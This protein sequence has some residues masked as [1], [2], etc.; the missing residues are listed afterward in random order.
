M[1]SF[2]VGSEGEI[3][4]L[5][6]DLGNFDRHWRSRWS[7]SDAAAEVVR[8]AIFTG[9][10]R[11][12]D[13][14]PFATIGEAMS[15]SRLPVREAINL[16]KHEGLVRVEPHRGSFVGPFDADVLREHW[17]MI[18]LLHGYAAA[19]LAGEPDNAAVEQLRA[20][21]RKL[22]ESTSSLEAGWLVFDFKRVL[23]AARTTERFRSI[24]RPLS[25]FAPAS[26]FGEIEEIPEIARRGCS[27]VLDAI[28]RADV[29]AVE[30]SCR[31]W[32]ADEGA[33]VIAHLRQIGVLP[34]T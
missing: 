23:N 22:E 11:P 27:G 5:L 33:S 12:G 1:T 20:V 4:A 6:E 10:L 19:R 18:G 15:I 31:D 24:I 2:G 29:D 17:A 28:E 30:R 26:L 13:Q 16:L 8:N 21:L 34:P 14:I 3:A 25:V 7:A 9:R 32:A